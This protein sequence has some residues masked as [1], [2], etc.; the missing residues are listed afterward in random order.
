MCPQLLL[1]VG[2]ETAWLAALWLCIPETRP[3]SCS[4]PL[5]RIHLSA[6]RAHTKMLLLMGYVCYHLPVVYVARLFRFVDF[7][8]VRPKVFLLLGAITALFYSLNWTG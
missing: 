6:A 1:A 2:L 4:P 8:A 5:E 7:D 3:W